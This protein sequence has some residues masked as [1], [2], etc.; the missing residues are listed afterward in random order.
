[1]KELW[2]RFVKDESGEGLVE[3]ILIIAIVAIGLVSAL[4]L[5]RNN[6]GRTLVDVSNTPG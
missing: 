4:L 6:V 1:M 5:F 3:Y 2:T